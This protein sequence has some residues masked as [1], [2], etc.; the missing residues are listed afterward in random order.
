MNKNS[1]RKSTKGLVMASMFAAL[2]C[3]A[4][5]VIKVPS[6]LHG[7]VNIGD[8]VVLL[9]GWLL[10]PSYAFMASGIGSAM[11]DV[12]G[13][14]VL[15]APATFVIKGLMAVIAHKMVKKAKIIGG[16][17]AEAVMVAGYLLFESLIYGFAPSLANIPAN[18]VQGV[19]CLCIALFMAYFTDKNPDSF[20]F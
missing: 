13:G 17:V 8:S 4:T 3:V 16:F 15:Y 2:T 20:R 11:A 10:P 6:P 7:Y 9:A 19:I 12:F 18:C 5:M 1:G 14:Y